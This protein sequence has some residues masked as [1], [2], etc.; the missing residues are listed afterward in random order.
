MAIL[1]IKI[2]NYYLKYESIYINFINILY[3]KPILK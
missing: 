3:I 1:K 2:K